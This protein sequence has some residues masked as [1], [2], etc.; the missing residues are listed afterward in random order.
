MYKNEPNVNSSF[1]VNSYFVNQARTA[2]RLL[3]SSVS[4][5][6]LKV[7]VQVFT[8]YT[9][10]QAI[11][12]AG[13][14]IVFLDIDDSYALDAECLNKQIKN[15]DVLIITHTFGF[16]DKIVAASYLPK[17]LIIIEDCAHSFGS[18]YMD[19]E[20]G[21]I[22]DAAIYSF[23]LG[24]WPPIGT[25][26]LA[27]VN[28]HSKFPLIFSNWA[29]LKHRAI[30]LHFDILLLLLE[31][32]ALSPIFYSVFAMIVKVLSKNNTDFVGKYKFNEFVGNKKI[33]IY[34]S[35][36]I[37][38]INKLL[39]ISRSNTLL[40]RSLI[41]ALSYPSFD[42]SITC[43]NHYIFPIMHELRDEIFND[44]KNNGITAG[45]HFQSSIEWAKRF[46]YSDGT[47][48]NAER[49]VKKILTL[50]VHPG[51]KKNSIKKIASI[52]NRYC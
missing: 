32:I 30:P 40:L 10:F 45:K 18:T 44:L 22:F 27:I 24:K 6:K 33:L 26:G 5:K 41:P 46:G 35:K 15:L 48:P 2:L 9:V 11:K 3:L 17:N 28:C 37:E 39:E 36:N 52:V 50:P 34:I 4:D 25:G 20:A 16:I 43:P 42:S 13:H 29:K 7:G 12:N 1:I 38:R 19:I 49:I 14:E 51:V 47:C 21:K 23:G 31:S 8:C